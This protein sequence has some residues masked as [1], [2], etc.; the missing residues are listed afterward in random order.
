MY[1]DTDI[2]LIEILNIL[3]YFTLQTEFFWKKSDL[4]A[5]QKHETVK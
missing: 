2:L 1:Y 4:K 3:V 5:P